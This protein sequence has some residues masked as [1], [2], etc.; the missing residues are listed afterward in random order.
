MS[1][2]FVNIEPSAAA[3][4]YQ[5]A[6][7]CTD[8]ERAAYEAGFADAKQKFGVELMSKIVDTSHYA[9]EKAVL[10]IKAN[11]AILLD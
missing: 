4:A 8:E 10:R 2:P 1:S 7:N 6:T 5:T 11:N 9:V 3:D